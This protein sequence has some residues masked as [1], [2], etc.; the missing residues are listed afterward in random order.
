MSRKSVLETLTTVQLMKQ[1]VMDGMTDERI[2]EIYHV[3]ASVVYKYR[4]KHNIPKTRAKCQRDVE[5]YIRMKEVGMTDE[6][7]A[8]VW[9]LSRRALV[10]W[11]ER[12]YLLGVCIQDKRV[13]HDVE[14]VVMRRKPRSRLRTNASKEVSNEEVPTM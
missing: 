9:N 5:E 1:H 4:V 10:S 6:N 14:K 12:E 2:A 13:M 3:S 8:Y 11:K 7:I